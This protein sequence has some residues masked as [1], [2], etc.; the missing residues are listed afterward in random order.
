MGAHLEKPRLASMMRHMLRG[1]TA[2]LGINVHIVSMSPGFDSV[3]RKRR[4]NVEATLFMGFRAEFAGSGH[5]RGVFV[6][7]PGF[8]VDYGD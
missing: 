3:R 2:S 8:P 1:I 6:G 5:D 7:A 4:R